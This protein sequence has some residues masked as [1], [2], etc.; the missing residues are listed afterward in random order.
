[1]INTMDLLFNLNTGSLIT[2]YSTT[3]KYNSVKYANYLDKYIVFMSTAN[4]FTAFS[5]DTLTFTIVISD[6]T[7]KPLEIIF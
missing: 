1:M 7:F 4:Q 2:G 6:T 5:L 3:I